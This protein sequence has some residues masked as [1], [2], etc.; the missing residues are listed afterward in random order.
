M[1]SPASAGPRRSRGRLWEPLEEAFQED[2]DVG[3]EPD[4][5]RV[6]S[7]TLL[8]MAF[9]TPLALAASHILASVCLLGFKALFKI[10]GPRSKSC[11]AQNV[12]MTS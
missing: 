2:V 3:P 1:Y 8:I 7:P 12:C 4:A 9:I 10:Q 6:R 11:I 5:V